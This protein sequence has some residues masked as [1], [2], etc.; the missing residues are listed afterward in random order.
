MVLNLTKYLG[1]GAIRDSIPYSNQQSDYASMFA[2]GIRLNVV[3][4]GAPNKTSLSSSVSAWSKYQQESGGM[5]MQIEGFNEINNF[6]FEYNGISPKDT[7]KGMFEAMS[8]L[9]SLVKSD[10]V[11]QSVPVLDLTGGGFSDGN[12]WGATNYSGRADYGTIHTYPFYGQQSV[13]IAGTKNS[14]LGSIGGTYTYWT[15]P[16]QFVTTEIGYHTDT[17][18]QG[19][20]EESFSKLIVN[21]VLNS[22]SSGLRQAYLY[23]LI[24]EY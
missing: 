10:S 11:L 6:Q 7:Y 22:L 12:V 24:D 3:A 1:V 14:F 4:G 15:D 21:I 8:D 13:C 16:S 18:P 23:E 20:T 5:I 17:F 2:S 9:Y 19:V